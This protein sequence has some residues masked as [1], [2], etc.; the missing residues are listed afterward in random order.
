M[1]FNLELPF[2]VAGFCYIYI[3]MLYC[4]WPLDWHLNQTLCLCEGYV[5][6][7]F[8]VVYKRN[9]KIATMRRYGSMVGWQ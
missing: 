4:G 9:L 8:I 1:E 7:Y 3:R 6:L 2:S 5:V